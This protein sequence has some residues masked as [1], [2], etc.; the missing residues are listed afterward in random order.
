MGSDQQQLSD[1]IK[2]LYLLPDKCI[3]FMILAVNQSSKS[4]RVFKKST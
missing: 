2:S 1:K 4:A 3:F